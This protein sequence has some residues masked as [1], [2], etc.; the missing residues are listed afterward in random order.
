[1]LVWQA[2]FILNKSFRDLHFFTKNKSKSWEGSINCSHLSKESPP[3]SLKRGLIDGRNST[4][5]SGGYLSSGKA[6]TIGR[7]L[8]L[9]EA[10]LF[11]LGLSCAIY[12]MR[13]LKMHPRF[14][15]CFGSWTPSDGLMKAMS[16]LYGEKKAYSQTI[17]PC[18]HYP[19]SPA[20]P[21]WCAELQLRAPHK[22][23][24]QAMSGSEIIPSVLGEISCIVVLLL[25]W[26]TS[27]GQDLSAVV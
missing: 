21:L 12:T 26:L 5:E 15:N 2:G 23:C 11:N 24:L 22:I 20:G 16:P 9:R 10:L 8:I 19:P 25:E 14:L 7:C 18:S 4:L 13:E 1:M 6:W 17:S 27:V 3:S